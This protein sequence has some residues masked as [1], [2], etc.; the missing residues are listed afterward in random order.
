MTTGGK[1][2]ISRSDQVE[3]SL[4]YQCN[5]PLPE[6]TNECTGTVPSLNSDSQQTVNTP[7]SQSMENQKCPKVLP[8]DTEESKCSLP[9]ETTSKIT[10]VPDTTNT[11]D[12]PLSEMDGTNSTSS[13]SV[14][15]DTTPS[16]Q[17]LPDVTEDTSGLVF[18]ESATNVM[19]NE[20]T[21]LEMPDQMIRGKLPEAT[22]NVQHDETETGISNQALPDRTVSDST[23]T[24]ET[25]NKDG[26]TITSISKTSEDTA[27]K[28]LNASVSLH[29]TTECALGTI[30]ETKPNLGDGS[31]EQIV[32]EITFTDLENTIDNSK[33]NVMLGDMPSG[34]SE[35]HPLETSSMISDPL[36]GCV[37]ETTTTTTS[38]TSDNPPEQDITHTAKKARLK[39]CIIRLTELSNSEHE[40]WL[41]NES[42]SSKINRSMESIENSTSS[43]SRYNMRTRPTLVGA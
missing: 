4:K 25:D 16:A 27:N 30:S 5:S 12:I 15:P 20:D 34:V 39:S 10:L 14:Y 37:P 7:Q 22:E 29:D 41:T 1:I 13:I 28:Q 43:G 36:E 6:A 9:D 17:T 2:I 18:T 26:E 35:M 23:P 40:K 11:T 19:S 3:I 21:T 8:N 38:T 42:S 31:K 32:G 24:R 33:D